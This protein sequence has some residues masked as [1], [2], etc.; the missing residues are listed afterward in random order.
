MIQNQ[1]PFAGF[2]EV[3]HRNVED[4]VFINDP[5]APSHA[6]FGD[7]EEE[8]DDV[9]SVAPSGRYRLDAEP[10]FEGEEAVSPVEQPT[11]RSRIAK[12]GW[13]S[14]SQYISSW[15]GDRRSSRPEERSNE[16]SLQSDAEEA[17]DA[18]HT[19]SSRPPSSLFTNEGD[20]FPP[21][22]ASSLG[23][24]ASSTSVNH[25]P[26]SP[27]ERRLEKKFD[28]VSEIDDRDE[29]VIKED[30]EIEQT[31]RD[32]RVV[33]DPREQ[34]EKSQLMTYFGFALL[35]QKVEN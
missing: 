4:S 30:D 28:E 8:E 27:V 18:A 32:M 13:G 33:V 34:Q 20:L 25:I 2:A 23:T 31:L 3:S 24:T 11:M 5:H 22:A 16:E 1:G 15:M 26:S 35:V 12:T 21:R 10:R 19:V 6:H 14:A 9:A 7:L 17:S 29:E